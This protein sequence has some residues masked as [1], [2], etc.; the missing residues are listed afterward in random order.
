MM[1]FFYDSKI[2]N[3]IYRNAR[4]LD[5]TRW[6]YHF[7]NGSRE[8]VLVA[9]SEYQ[10]EDGGFGHALEA[11]S[12]NPN[13]SPIQTYAAIE[14]LKEIDFTQKGHPMIQGI[15][16]YLDSGADFSGGIWLNTVTSNNDYPHA[17]WWHTQSVS[18]SHDNYNPTAGLIGFV[19]Y[20]ADCSS[21]LYQKCLQIA[22]KAINYLLQA[23]QMD[24][25]TIMCFISLMDYCKLSQGIDLLPLDP[26]QDKL[27]SLVSN[28]ITKDTSVW[29]TSYICK[30]SRFF[31]TKDSFFYEDNKE[32]AMYECSFI[33][34]SRNMEGIWDI[35]WEWTDYPEEWAVSKNW[36]KGDLVI[37][38]MLFVKG[39]TAK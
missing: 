36:W 25:H 38:N 3:W 7:E 1:G 13:S 27:K 19:L 14:I 39:M 26:M 24:M 12:W 6:Q 16:K 11:D 8:A 33:Q 4:P 9:L 32:I 23:E 15:L 10:N 22:T 21:E 20:F 37:K 34:S 18:T 5:L 35:T 28:S 2:R 17:P 30:P 31:N 29:A